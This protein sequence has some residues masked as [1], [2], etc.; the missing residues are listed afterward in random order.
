MTENVAVLRRMMQLFI[1][2]LKR[3]KSHLKNFGKFKV[4]RLWSFVSIIIGLLFKRFHCGI[5]S[6]SN[7]KFSGLIFFSEIPS[8]AAF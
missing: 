8:G 4:N 7:P 5:F 1:C 6:G 3:K 2:V